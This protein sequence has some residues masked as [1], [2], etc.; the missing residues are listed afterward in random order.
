MSAGNFALLS[1]ASSHAP[2]HKKEKRFKKPYTTEPTRQLS[3]LK[4]TVYYTRQ[5]IRTLGHNTL[6][7]AAFE[8]F[9]AWRSLRL[10][11]RG[12]HKGSKGVPVAGKRRVRLG[13]GTESSLWPIHN[14]KYRI[15][16]LRLLFM[17]ETLYTLIAK[18]AKKSAI[19]DRNKYWGAEADSLEIMWSSGRIR[20]LYQ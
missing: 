18:K 6:T 10:H 13:G 4:E 12:A 7:R 11:L 14:V 9:R 2:S 5:K 1:A 3:L 8:T 19:Q 20:D 17:I 16:Y 15:L